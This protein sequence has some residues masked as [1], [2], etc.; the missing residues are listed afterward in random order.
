MQNNNM[1]LNF[2]VKKGKIC[3]NRNKKYQYEML[4]SEL[5]NKQ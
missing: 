3:G 4:A 2:E 5:C 1:H